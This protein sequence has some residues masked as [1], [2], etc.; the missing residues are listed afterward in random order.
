MDDTLLGDVLLVL[1]KVVV[2][3]IKTAL[4]LVFLSLVSSGLS[5]IHQILSDLFHCFF[6]KFMRRAVYIS[7]WDRVFDDAV[8]IASAFVFYIIGSCLFNWNFLNFK[9]F[10]DFLVSTW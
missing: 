8:V 10:T 7:F 6:P 1:A 3:T 5:F 4:F 2:Y 9:S